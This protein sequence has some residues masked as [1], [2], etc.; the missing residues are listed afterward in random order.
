MASGETHD[1][2]TSADDQYNSDKADMDFELAWYS[3][4]DCSRKHK[5]WRKKIQED[6]ERGRRQENSHRPSFSGFTM[7]LV[8]ASSSLLHDNA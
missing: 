6:G 3:I 2:K 4:W 7:A 1:E 5:A 8:L